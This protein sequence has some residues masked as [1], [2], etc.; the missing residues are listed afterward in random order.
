MASSTD[1]ANGEG[2]GITSKINPLPPDV[3]YSLSKSPV[4]KSPSLL[5]QAI[6][7]ALFVVW[8]TTTSITIVLTQFIGAPLALWD[9]EVFYAYFFL[10][11]SIE[12][13]LIFR[14]ISNTK[15]SFGVTVTTITQ[16]Y[17]IVGFRG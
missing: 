14:Y 13:V 6:R 8:F 16:W 1:H 10:R 5:E 7:L 17:D 12:L 11:Y 3:T 4:G 2:E 9:E 15:K